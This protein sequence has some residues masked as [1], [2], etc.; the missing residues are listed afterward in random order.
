M[1]WNGTVDG[2]KLAHDLAPWVTAWMPG[3]EAR[4]EV[5]YLGHG[6]QTH[7]CDDPD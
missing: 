2:L 6:Q 4:P 7:D 3:V 1:E 5:A